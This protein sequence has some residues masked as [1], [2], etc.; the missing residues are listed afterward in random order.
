MQPD[1]A[2]RIKLLLFFVE[3]RLWGAGT[4]LYLTTIADF[5]SNCPQYIVIVENYPM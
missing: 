1:A 2:D 3:N 4:V 5:G